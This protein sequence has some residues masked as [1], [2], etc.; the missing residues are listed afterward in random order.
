M[1][2]PL[3]LPP[4]NSTP[5]SPLAK[6]R[7][8]AQWQP[9]LEQPACVRVMAHAQS[10][11]HHHLAPPA[12]VAAHGEPPLGTTSASS[13]YDSYVST[14]GGSDS[15]SSGLKQQYAAAADACAAQTP[16]AASPEACGPSLAPSTPPPAPPRSTHVMHMS[17]ASL[18]LILL[19]SFLLAIDAFGA[20]MIPSSYIA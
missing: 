4:S 3:L 13:S 6:G 2:Q 20:G 16:P 10:I 7:V 11:G 5:A 14:I 17:R 19:L 18:R 15:S 12:P 9:D 8:G 1:R